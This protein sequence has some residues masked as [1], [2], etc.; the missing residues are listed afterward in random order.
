MFVRVKKHA[1][2]KNSSV[3]ICY[4]VRQ[5]HRVQQKILNRVGIAYSPEDLSRLKAQAQQQLKALKEAKQNAHVETEHS[6]P[7]LENIKEISRQN[8]GVSDILGNLYDTLGFSRILPGKAG[9]ILKSVVLSRFMEPSSKRKVSAILERNFGEVLQTDA[10]YRMMDVLVE[11][12]SNSSKIVFQATRQA[13]EG[14]I[15]VVLFDVTTLHF[16]SIEKDELRA[17]GFSKNFRFNTT[18]VILALA[19]TNT[20]LPIGYRLFSGNTAEVSTLIECVTHW[21]QDLSIGQV[22]MIG[23]RAMMSQDNLIKLEAAGMQYIIAYPMKKAS[24]DLQSQILSGVDYKPDLIQNELY[25]H[26]E[27]KTESSQRLIVTYSQKRHAKDKKQRDSLIEKIEKKIG[28]KKTAKCLV[29]NKGYLKYTKMDSQFVAEL[30]RRKIEEDEQWD[31]LHGILTNTEL[32]AKAV[33][34]RYKKLWIIEEAFR[35]NK[36]NMEMRPIYHYTPKRILA[37][38]EICFLTFA[39][40]RHAQERLKKADYAISIDLLREELKSIEVSILCDQSS[41][42]LYKLPSHVTEQGRAIYKIFGQEQ[43]LK[44]HPLE[45]REKSECFQFN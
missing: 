18:Q 37:H 33:V 23:D 41:G 42:K 19:T 14:K 7:S 36:H 31:G 28:V 16:E 5:G 20:G 10:I 4:S 17:F 45:T 35:I 15:D 12:L 1:G 2:S 26:R 6:M 21:K 30:N 22:I 39:L 11:N 24:K 29:S 44:I 34:E 13:T 32:S 43:D 27:F 25:W 38:I 8:S 9:K 3:L 40:L